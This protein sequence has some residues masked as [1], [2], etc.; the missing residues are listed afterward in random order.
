MKK[1]LTTLLVILFSI[2]S[3]QAQR[4]VK[5]AP[6]LV[7]ELAKVIKADSTARR[8]AAPQVT[9]Y[10][11]KRNGYYPV[12]SAIENKD[13]F[14]Y[15]RAEAGTA[16][17]P[18]LQASPTSG[19]TYAYNINF[20][21]NGKLENLILEANQPTGGVRNRYI[22]VYN[23]ASVWLTSCEI[24]H[25]RGSVIAL[26]SNDCSLY[27]DDCFMHS[28][29]HP[30][31]LG[32]NG[33]VVDLR[34]IT[35]ADT[36]IVRNCTF[37]NLT[38]RIMRNMG[39]TVNYVEFDHNTSLV[40][41]GYHGGLQAG[42]A[43]VLKVTNNI[44]R[45]TIVLG[46]HWNRVKPIGKVVEQTQP[47]NTNMYVVTI[48]TSKTFAQK[49]TVRNNNIY[50]EK[51]YT[52]IWAKY[53]DSTKAPGILT[54][55][56]MKALGADSTKAYYSEELT[57]QKEPTDI[58]AWVEAAIKT[59]NATDMPENWWFNY[60]EN[61]PADPTKT[62][63][64]SYGTTAK[65]YTAGDKSLPVGDLNWYP[66]KK[67]LYTGIEKFESSIIPSSIELMQNYPNPFNPVTNISYSIPKNS[68][69]KL[70][71]FDM[72]GREVATLVNETQ[73]AGTY[74]VDF[75]ASKLSS[76][77]YIYSLVTAG[78]SFSKKMI[79]IK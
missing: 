11:L 29:G 14:L 75:D 78:Q 74:K 20:R 57:F 34:T 1:L 44:F 68:A 36:I 35:T 70:V 71:V 50:W 4:I 76:G 22:N 39:T 33:R 27:I 58:V 3:I 28:I 17:K 6:D 56:I 41:E 13:F 21:S 72:L 46:A 64:A 2:S 49:I 5:V 32:G 42:K 65:S 26:Q 8:A 61:V 15:I 54:S 77:V 12:V 53:K 16:P 43:K 10:E 7:D 24:M 25:D 9:I 30:K 37:F 67:K 62:V 47:E 38:D 63:V 52:D 18:L 60:Q 23:G 31:S 45:N 73:Q 79:L 51:K 59:P 48:D 55:T 19:T 66:D 69:V 40:T